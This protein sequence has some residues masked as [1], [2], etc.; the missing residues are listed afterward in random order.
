MAS[1]RPA[2]VLRLAPS[3]EFWSAERLRQHLSR[4][5]QCLAVYANSDIAITG[6]QRN[7]LARAWR[8]VVRAEGPMPFWATLTPA[9]PLTLPNPR[10]PSDYVSEAATKLCELVDACDSGITLSAWFHRTL[11][12]MVHFHCEFEGFLATKKHPW[13]QL[14]QVAFD[15]Q[16]ANFQV[17]EGALR[18]DDYLVWA[19]DG[20]VFLQP[21]GTSRA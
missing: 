6:Q 14:I 9:A 7:R 5:P 15:L 2:R 19:S 21:S 8:P 13:H 16:Q 1:V 17:P 12:W 11:V 20:H 4:M 10:G 3:C 18:T